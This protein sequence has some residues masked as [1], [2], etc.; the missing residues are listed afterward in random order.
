M[1]L[2]EILTFSYN[3]FEPTFETELQIAHL[4]RNMMD[5]SEE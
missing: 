3:N 2:C 4:I 1:K 5:T